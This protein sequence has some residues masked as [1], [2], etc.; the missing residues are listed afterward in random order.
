[1]PPVTE[2]AVL[3]ENRPILIRS[4][5]YIAIVIGA[6][7]LLLVEAVDEQILRHAREFIAWLTGQ[8]LQLAGFEARVREERVFLSRSAVQIVNSCTGVDVAIFLS[9]AVLVFPAPWR[10]RLKG[11]LLSFA[12]VF[13]VNFLRVLTLC[14]FVNTS[15]ELFELTHIYIWPAF[16]TLVCLGTLLFWIQTMAQPPL[17]AEEAQAQG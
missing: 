2:R 16:I 9:A 7:N 6:S 5:L 13:V 12:V 15:Q 4:A 3:E 17:A 8:A 11:V 14:F 10:A 1:M